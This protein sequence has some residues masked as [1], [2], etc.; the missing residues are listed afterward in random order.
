MGRHCGQPDRM[1][2]H[3]NCDMQGDLTRATA[4]IVG[5]I[6]SFVVC[7]SPYMHANIIHD[8]SLN[9]RISVG[10]KTPYVERALARATRQDRRICT[11]MV[12]HHDRKLD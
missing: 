3:K 10:I 4:F 11:I 12:P 7:L 9:R 2:V 1:E 8:Q 6:H 5:T